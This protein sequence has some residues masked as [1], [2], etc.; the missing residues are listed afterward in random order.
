MNRF[1]AGI[2]KSTAF[3][4]GAGLGDRLKY[5]WRVN[6]DDSGKQY[7]PREDWKEVSSSLRSIFDWQIET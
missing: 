7:S 6:K 1:G 5:Y 3:Y 2:G 4:N